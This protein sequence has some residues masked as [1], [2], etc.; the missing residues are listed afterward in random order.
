MNE[1][2]PDN[3]RGEL[4]TIEELETEIEKEYEE[5]KSPSQ[6]RFDALKEKLSNLK[7][8]EIKQTATTPVLFEIIDK[9]LLPLYQSILNRLDE[10]K[11]LFISSY[12]EWKAKKESIVDIAS[13]A[14]QWKDEQF[15]KSNYNFNFDYWLKGFKKAGTETFSI[16]FQLNYIIADYWYGFSLINFND[17]QPFLKKLYHEQLTTQ[18]I[19]LISDTVYNFLI[20]EIERRIEQIK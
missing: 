13:L 11:E 1:S 6:K 8:T 14:E 16:S 10:F 20:D 7:N 12:Y 5:L 15:L 19:E 4:P 18:D 3:I 17:Q 9:G 2:L